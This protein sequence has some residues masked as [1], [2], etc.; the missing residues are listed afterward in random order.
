M[1]ALE[2]FNA[3]PLLRIEQRS[4]RDES[5]ALCS[6]V[7]PAHVA[8]GPCSHVLQPSALQHNTACTAI[9]DTDDIHSADIY[10]VDSN[11]TYLAWFRAPVPYQGGL[12]WTVAAFSYEGKLPYP[13]STLHS[14]VGCDDISINI[15]NMF[16]TISMTISR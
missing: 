16:L 4:G 8:L 6:S 2:Q 1:L 15:D 14:S 13:D 12:E 10:I 3:F 5:V 11:V 7:W 9:L